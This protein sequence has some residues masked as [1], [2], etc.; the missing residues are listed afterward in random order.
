MIYGW[1]RM[2]YFH[3]VKIWYN[4]RSFIYRRHISPTEGGYHIED[5]SPVP[6]GT[7][8]IEKDRFLTESVF[9]CLTLYLCICD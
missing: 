7:D 6:Q 5:I 8:I 3:F 2:I 1:H 9:F 4:V